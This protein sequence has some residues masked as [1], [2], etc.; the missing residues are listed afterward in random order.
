MRL[1]IDPEEM[2]LRDMEDF[3]AASGATMA[4][5]V[6]MF[7]GKPE[8]E[9]RLT[10]FPPRMLTAMV[11][12]FGRKSDPTLTLDGARDVRLVDL[13]AEGPPSV[14]GGRSGSGSRRS[15]SSTGTRRL[16]SKR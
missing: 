4:Q 15:P 3:E 2:T 14:A 6:G 9:I 16:S 13:E 8:T 7:E 12:V 5:F 10:D 1:V 11:W